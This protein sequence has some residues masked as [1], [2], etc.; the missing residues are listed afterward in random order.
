[1]KR[2]PLVSGIVL[3]TKDLKMQIASFFLPTWQ[4][5]PISYSSGCQKCRSMILS[6][7]ARD[8]TLRCKNSHTIVSGN[9]IQS[10]LQL[11]YLCNKLPP[12]LV[13]QNNNLLCSQWVKSSDRTQWGQLVSVPMSEAAAGRLRGWEL[14]SSEGSFTHMLNG[15][16][17]L[18]P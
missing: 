6:C 4:C 13:A 9:I 16:C 17:W 12:N 1:M 8:R 5:C 10:M 11:V 14:E 18:I 2:N 15:W 3:G 7:F